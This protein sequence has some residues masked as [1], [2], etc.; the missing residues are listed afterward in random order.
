MSELARFQDAFIEAIFR[1]PV[2]GDPPGLA[3]YR[4]TVWRGLIDALQAAYPAVARITGPEWFEACAGVYVRAHPPSDPVLARYGA[5]FPDFLRRFPPAA[6]LPYLSET[7]AGERLW[8]EAH[9]AAEAP[10]FAPSSPTEDNLLDRPL[11][12]HPAVRLQRF[13]YPVGALLRLG[14]DADTPECAFGHIAW[15]SEIVGVFRPGGAVAIR[16]LDEGQYALLEA[17]CKG[18]PLG[19]ALLAAIQAGSEATAS[20]GLSELVGLGAFTAPDP[21]PIPLKEPCA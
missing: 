11:R 15:R 1:P 16:V 2:Q 7:A 5:E 8:I 17:C 6:E 13:Q 3:V 21:N 19:E 10:P 14:R 9:L 18:R 4:N 12:L 20:A